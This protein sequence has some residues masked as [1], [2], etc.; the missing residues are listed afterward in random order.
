MDVEGR[1][2]VWLLYGWFTG[3]MCMGSV[4]GVAAWG[5]FMHFLVAFYTAL[6]AANPV[7]I[8]STFSQAQLG[9]SA[10]FVTYAIAFM[11]LSVAQ[12]LVLDRMA[13][14]AVAKGNGMSRRLAVG[15][16]VVM[17]AVVVGNAVGLCGNVASAVYFKQ[18]ADLYSEASAAYAANKPD[19]GKA[20][21]S[22]GRRKN[23]MASNAASVQQFS[24]VVVLLIIIVAFA[25]VGIASA[26]R[27]SSALRNLNDAHGAV[28][29]A[30]RQLRLQIV[31]TTAFIF[32]TFLLRSVF[33]IM[34]ALANGLQNNGASC[35]TSLCDGLC[36]NSYSLMQTWFQY[37][38]HFQHTFEL[39]SSPLALLVALWGMT[40]GRTLQRLKSNRKQMQAVGDDAV[41]RTTP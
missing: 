6:D 3:L 24:E 39:I 22:Q 7:V 2:Q 14:F 16:R 21:R 27:V 11:C 23:E 4:F 15:G 40:Y 29:T 38:P 5:A 10:F 13:N 26:R 25:V 36:Y 8:C 17:A 1:S 20:V 41:L 31:G 28:D 32:V 18:S 35:A 37:T 33:S 9:R 12:L 34:Y 19:D 30:G